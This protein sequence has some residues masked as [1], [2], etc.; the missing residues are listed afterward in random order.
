M[1]GSNVTGFSLASHVSYAL[2]K[3]NWTIEG[4]DACSSGP[5]VQLKLTGCQEGSFTCDNGQCIQM[6]NR[7]DQIPDCRDKSDE[8]GCKL[9]VLEESY[10]KNIPPISS[11]IQQVPVD[12]SIDLLKLVRINEEVN[13]IEFQFMITLKWKESRVTYYNLKQKESQNILMQ[14]DVERLW[15]PEVIYENTDQKEISRLGVE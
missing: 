5:N 9:L 14:E 8:K 6:E 3:H 1:V 12:V 11:S 4:G 15:L 10:N 7:C 13:S 2:G